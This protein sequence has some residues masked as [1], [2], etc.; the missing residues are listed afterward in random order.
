MA[1]DAEVAAL[2]AVE[3]A[4]QQWTVISEQLHREVGEAAERHAGA[5]VESLRADFNA[6]LAVTRA[7]AAFARTCAQAGPD[8]DGLPGAAFVQALHHVGNQPGLDQALVELTHQWQSWLT[9]IGKWMPETDSPPP[10]RPTSPEHSRVL[11][12]VDDWWDFAADRLHEQLVDS[13]TAQG[14][15]VAESLTTGRD[16]EL[17]QSAHVIF[18]PDRSSEASDAHKRWA[19]ARLHAL[20]G[21]HRRR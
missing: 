11:A 20:F 18:E 4:Y 19:R 5:P 3:D 2:R 8:V 16:G 6:Q 10:A 12:A 1:R 13:L 14:H 9:D 15:R 7:V 17:V 21:P